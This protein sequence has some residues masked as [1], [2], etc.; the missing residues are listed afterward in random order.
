MKLTRKKISILILSP[1]GLMSLLVFLSMLLVLMALPAATAQTAKQDEA[2]RKSEAEKLIEQS[3]Q[4]KL[5]AARYHGAVSAQKKDAQKLSSE[6]QK[7]STGAHKLNAE[8]KDKVE[9]GKILKLN[10]AQYNLH[11]KE[12]QDHARLYNAHLADYEK[13]VLAAQATAGAL[14]SSCRQYAD[15][16]EKYHIPGL[17]P[18]HVCVQ[19]QWEEKGMQRAARGFQEDQLKSQKAEAELAKQEAQLAQ[20]AHERA[21][22]EAKLLQ[23]AN[24]DELE[25]TQGA[26]LLKEYQQI[27]REYRMLG[28]EKT[29]IERK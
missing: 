27:E 28:Q 12:F 14:K 7:L 13:Q 26:M 4:F 10:T 5:K 9:L 29:N 6:A 18:P 11:L 3:K 17:R 25:R 21:D 1:A 20:V 22:L 15:H 2:A 8:F 23:K 19:L 16:V 24:I